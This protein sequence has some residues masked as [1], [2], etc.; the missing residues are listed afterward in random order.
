MPEDRDLYHVMFEDPATGETLGLMLTEDAGPIG[1]IARLS[2]PY[3]AKVGGGPTTLADLTDLSVYAQRDWHG[4]RGQDQAEDEER[5]YDA[6]SLETRIKNQIT[7][8]PLPVSTG[9]GDVPEYTPSDRIGR[10]IG[11]IGSTKLNRSQSFAAPTGGMTVT[12]VVMRIRKSGAGG[13]NQITVTI[14]TDSSGKP[15]GTLAHANATKTVDVDD[16]PTIDNEVQIVFPASFTLASATTYHLCVVWASPRLVN[17]GYVTWSSDTTPG[18]SGG[19]ACYQA[20]PWTVGGTAI[21]GADEIDTLTWTAETGHD[22]WFKI[23]DGPVLAGDI[24]VDPIRY[25]NKWYCAADDTVYEWSVASQ[26]WASSDAVTDEDVTAMAVFAGYL[27]AARG[28]NTMRRF[29]GTAWADDPGL[30][31]AQLL[32]R[33]SGYLYRSDPTDQDEMYYTQNGTDWDGPIYVGPGDWGITGIAGFQQKVAISNAVGMWL[34]SVDWTYEVLPWSSLEQENNGRGMVTWAKVNELFIPI[35]YSLWRW[36]GASM[37]SAGPDQD[38]GLPAERA[39]RVV[40]LCGT[41]NWLF[42][43]VDAG[44]SGYSSVMAYSGRGW[45]EI[46]RATAAGQR[47]RAIGYE[48][49]DDPPRLWWSV[50]DVM[51]YV[52]MPDYSDNPYAWSGV[53]FSSQGE[54]E[55]STWGSE[56]L[57]VIKDWRAVVL[58]VENC[59]STRT[60]EVQYEVDRSGVW[61]SV[62]TVETAHTIQVLEFPVS[63]F[64]QLTVGSSSTTTTIEVDTGSGPNTGDIEAGDWVQINDE[65][66]QVLSVTDS[67]TFVL[68]LPLTSAPAAGDTI[69]ASAPA[70]TEIRLKLILSTSD[71]TLTP[72]VLDVALFCDA[73]VSDRWVI[74]LDCEIGPDVRLLNQQPYPMSED[75]L[76]TEIERWIERKTPFTLHDMRGQE[77]TVKISNAAET[78]LQR[79]DSFPPRYSSVYRLSLIEVEV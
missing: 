36:S 62:G 39:G 16:L 32:T 76:A 18:Y 54:I 10:Q 50:D 66:R 57:N 19:S 22:F 45:H 30:T 70:G 68:A 77:R 8:G 52:E 75:S 47:I 78:Q 23:N 34:K 67:D 73:N 61:A 55:L 69:Y 40:A 20:R 15:S 79:D 17:S 48:T 1:R 56:L 9:V 71:S 7:L 44:A 41:V 64:A 13:A 25:N 3:A 2:N 37:I 74:N 28:A 11:Y 31:E 26:V 43:A 4:G 12:H 27:W 29:N 6:R 33:Y 53:A 5:F 49:L 35:Q 59:S 14:E 51:W 65:I 21:G 58:H 60:V 72:K 38:A 46:Y 63:S 24:V 42:A